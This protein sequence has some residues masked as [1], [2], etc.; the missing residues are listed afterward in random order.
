[1]KYQKIAL[2][3]ELLLKQQKEDQTDEEG[4]D[5]KMVFVEGMK[6]WDVKP[7]KT[8]PLIKTYQWAHTQ[9]KNAIY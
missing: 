7:P 2:F 4:I 9:K 1:M 5:L 8:N 6:R 3:S